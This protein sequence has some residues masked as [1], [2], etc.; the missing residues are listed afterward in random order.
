MDW[1]LYIRDLRHGRVEVHINKYL[2]NKTIEMITS[3]KS[4]EVP[5][6]SGSYLLLLR[7]DNDKVL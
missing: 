6:Y 3:F 1:F 4:Y 2:S 7:K 5:Y